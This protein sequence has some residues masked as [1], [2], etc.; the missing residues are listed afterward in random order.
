MSDR[1]YGGILENGPKEFTLDDFYTLQL[2]KLDRFNCL[3]ECPITSNEWNGSD[4]EGD[5]DSDSD[6]DEDENKSDGGSDSNDED[7]GIA[8]D[9]LMKDVELADLNLLTDVEIAAIEAAKAHAEK[10]ELRKRATAFMGVSTSADRSAEDVLSTPQ[11]GETLAAF[12]GRSRE[13][14]T[15]KAHANATG[16]RGKELRRDGFTLAEDAYS[17]Y[18]PSLPDCSA[19]ISYADILSRLAEE[20]QPLLE[21]IARI[22]AAA[23]LEADELARGARAGL[24]TDSRNRR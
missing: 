19:I 9:A 23:G 14:W 15:Q 21:E 13:F 22:Q 12:F 10:E 18:N 8:G 20:Y 16:N 24:G 3:K 2:D 4:S 5:D 11:P 7:D 1:S 17:K 6:D